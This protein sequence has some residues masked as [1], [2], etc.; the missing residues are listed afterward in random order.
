[1]TTPAATAAPNPPYSLRTAR[2][3]LRCPE[4]ADAA[5]RKAAVD[6]SAEHLNDLFPI[7]PEGPYPLDW[8]AAQ[9][10]KRR[11]GFDLDQDRGYIAFDPASGRLLGEAFL[12]RRAGLQALEIGYW[13]RADAVGHGLATEMSAAVVKT[14]FE[15]DAIRRLDLYCSPENERSAAMARRLGFTFEG[16][17]RDRQLAAHHPRGD[18]LCFTLLASEYPQTRARQLAIEAFDF[19]GRPLAWPRSDA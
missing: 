4:P 5:P 1:M 11:S 3:L 19:L 8:H 14:A 15:L 9:L 17:L 6:S 12:L 16:R 18:L 10:R 13:L 2:L 7:P